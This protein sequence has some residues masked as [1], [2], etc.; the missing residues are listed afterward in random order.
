MPSNEDVFITTNGY[1][2]PKPSVFKVNTKPSFTPSS[3]SYNSPSSSYGA[4]GLGDKKVGPSGLLVDIT[5][6][7]VEGIEGGVEGIKSLVSGVNLPDLPNPISKKPSGGGA[8]KGTLYRNNVK[9]V[10]KLYSLGELIKIAKRYI[11]RYY[12]VPIWY[13]EAIYI[14]SNRAYKFV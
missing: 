3:S 8:L 1:N 13:V 7:V 5:K 6:S 4:G 2:P 9:P 11:C 10:M 14:F 12:V